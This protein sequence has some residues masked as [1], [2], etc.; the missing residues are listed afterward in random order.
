[1]S[2]H[3]RYWRLLASPGAAILLIAFAGNTVLAVDDNDAGRVLQFSAPQQDAARAIGAGDL[4][5]RAVN[6]YTTVVPG[7]SG[8]YTTLISKFKI[9]VIEGTSDV[10]T[11]EPG[12]YNRAAPRYAARYNGYLFGRFGCDV[13]HPMAPCSHYP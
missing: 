8:D 10:L 12:D 11:N 9:T 2:R 7:I 13:E 3:P 5:L 1:M 6:R 4:S